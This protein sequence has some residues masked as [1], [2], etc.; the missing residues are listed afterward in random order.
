MCNFYSIWQIF[1][2]QTSKPNLWLWSVLVH[3]DKV[4]NNKFVYALNKRQGQRGMQNSRKHVWKRRATCVAAYICLAA[5]LCSAEQQ[6]QQIQGCQK[7]EFL[8]HQPVQCL[9][10]CLAVSSRA[11]ANGCASHHGRTRISDSAAQTKGRSSLVIRQ[12]QVRILCP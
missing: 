11:A 6:K 5:T 9:S 2:E 8:P 7:A 1:N 12:V 4:W 10:L 3:C